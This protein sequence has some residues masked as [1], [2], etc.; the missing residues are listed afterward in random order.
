[1]R[2]LDDFSENRMGWSFSTHCRINVQIYWLAEQPS[3][4][5]S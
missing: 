1:M 4:W 5:V 3:E 2:C